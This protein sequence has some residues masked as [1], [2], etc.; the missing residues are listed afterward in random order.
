MG[1]TPHPIPARILRIDA[2]VS[3]EDYFA[4]LGVTLENVSMDIEDGNPALAQALND[5]TYD[6]EYLQRNYAIVRKTPS[7]TNRHSQ[8]PD[9]LAPE[10]Y[11]KISNP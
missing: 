11:R 4:T 7:E 9:T 3:S 2:A 8:I 5:L 1:D 6:L 10:T